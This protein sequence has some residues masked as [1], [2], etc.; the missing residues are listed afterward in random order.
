MHNVRVYIYLYTCERQEQTIKETGEKAN[1][2]SLSLFSLR[3]KSVEEERKKRW[4]KTNRK[5]KTNTCSL[6]QFLSWTG[7]FLRKKERVKKKPILFV[8]SG[9]SRPF[10][11]FSQRQ[12]QKKARVPAMLKRVLLPFF[13]RV[14]V[15]MEKNLD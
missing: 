7:F 1:A 5:D 12:E 2:L 4:G 10:V 14:L 13:S 15:L 8:S 3:E 11:F 6:C 9:F